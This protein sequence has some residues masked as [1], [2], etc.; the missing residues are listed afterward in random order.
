MIAIKKNL[1]I[2]AAAKKLQSYRYIQYIRQ[3]LSSQ[4][5]YFERT[6]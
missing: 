2:K 6:W 3:N 1:P 5:A 4:T